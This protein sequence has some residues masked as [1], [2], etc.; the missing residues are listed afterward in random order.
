VPNGIPG[1]CLDPGIQ[2]TSPEKSA[3]AGDELPKPS[4]ARAEFPKERCRDLA[5]A[6]E[7]CAKS[8]P[9]SFEM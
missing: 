7:A 9:Y 1:K 5:T 2:G 4:L 8:T 3:G 6:E